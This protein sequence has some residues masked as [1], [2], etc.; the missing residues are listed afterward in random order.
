MMEPVMVWVLEAGRPSHQVPRFHRMAAIR[1]ANTMA[2]P[3]PELTLR[4]NSTGSRV[5]MVKATVPAEVSTPTR[6][7]QAGPDHSDVWIERVGIDDRGNG[8]CGV[9]ESV[10]KLEPEGDEQRH[11]KKQ[12]W[13]E[14]A[15]GGVAQIAGHVEADVAEATHQRNEDNN[16]ANPAGHLLFP[17]EQRC[18]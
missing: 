7:P 8:V 5:M 12:V 15:Q 4:I 13:P 2:K 17:V 11:P 10:Y 9:M 3:A 16:A 1:R 14:A 6:L 18:A